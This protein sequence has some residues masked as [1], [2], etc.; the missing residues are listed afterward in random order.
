M[1]ISIDVAK[2]R[3]LEIYL[4]IDTNSK[5]YGRLLNWCSNGVWHYGI[6][7][8]DNLIFDTA[9]LALFEP[10]DLDIL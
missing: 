2:D 5:Y 10:F 9:S 7:I 1:T 3:I 8:S 6:G 4:K